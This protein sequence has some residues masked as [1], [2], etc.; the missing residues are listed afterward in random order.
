MKNGLEINQTKQTIERSESASTSKLETE[1]SSPRNTQFK[2]S[3]SEFNTS[4]VIESQKRS[5]TVYILCGVIGTLLLGLGVFG[6]MK[7]IKNKDSN[8]NFTTPAV[9]SVSSTITSSTNNIP[10]TT[11]TTGAATTVAQQTET[12]ATAAVITTAMQ[13]VLKEYPASDISNYPQYIS[14]IKDGIDQNKFDAKSSGYALYDLNGDNTPE[15]IINTALYG[16]YSI[17]GNT[18][19]ELIQT[20]TVPRSPSLALTDTGYLVVKSLTP[21]G[22]SSIS[23]YK[24]N[25]GTNGEY[26]DPSPEQ[27]GTEVAINLTPITNITEFQSTDSIKPNNYTS[28]DTSEAPSDFIFFSNGPYDPALGKVWTEEGAL[29]LRAKPSTDSEIIIQMPKSSYINI[30]GQNNN[31]CYVSYSENGI[32]YFGYASRQFIADGGI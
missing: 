9:E 18:Y 10:V 6:G 15:M 21:Q 1:S 31:W 7:L 19:S 26:E 22:E 29:N 28:Y 27:I 25:G 2:E 13:K 3:D 16:V 20:Y 5:P 14:A 32:T 8:N 4:Y 23:Y 12:T 11:I 17:N 24:F 30:F